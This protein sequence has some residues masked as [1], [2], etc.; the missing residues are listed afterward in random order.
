MANPQIV[1][2]WITIAGIF[3]VGSLAGGLITQYVLSKQR[4]Q[5]WAKDNKKQE[6]RELIGTL[7]RSAHLFIETS[8]DVGLTVI[9]G[10][11][12]RAIFEANGEA[13][14]I[15]EDRIFIASE[16]Q[17]ENVLERWQ[18]LVA[19]NRLARMMEYWNHL[20]STLVAAARKDC[21]MKEQVGMNYRKGFLRL[22]TVLAVCW[23]ALYLAVTVSRPSTPFAE[24][25]LPSE[26][27]RPDFYILPEEQQRRLLADADKDFAGL[28]LV[29]QNKVLAYLAT[30]LQK[31]RR[32]R[33]ASTLEFSLIPPIVGF[34]LFFLIVPWI[35]AGF[36]PN[37]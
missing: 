4:H 27:K 30:D 9:T 20:H 36:R 29:E 17:R 25:T 15:I 10:A 18:L 26:L 3:G 28:P 37:K 24:T 32:K 16:V 1:P 35:A 11:Q 5:E 7:T 6:W 33:L 22:Y 21:G 31:Y 23:I 8:T 12:E 34:A 2:L 14:R 19:E 13:R